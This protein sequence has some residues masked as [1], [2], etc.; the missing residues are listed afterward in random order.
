VSLDHTE[1][2]GSFARCEVQDHGPGLAPEE[3]QRVWQRFYRVAGH[4]PQEGSHFGLGL[5]LY[6][7]STIVERHGGQIGVESVPDEGSTFW[8][9][10][11][12]AAPNA[13]SVAQ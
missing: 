4:D 7:S 2:Q 6:I 13:S 5:G 8:F 10:L 3:Q 12:L 9:T 11:P 1:G